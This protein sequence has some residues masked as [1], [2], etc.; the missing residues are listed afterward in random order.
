M[1]QKTEA[2]G[3]YDQIAS[4]LEDC[5]AHAKGDLTLK[6][7][8]LPAPPPKV[9]AHDIAALRRSLRMSQSVFAAVLNVSLKTIQ[10]WEQ[11]LREPNEASL[12]LI[13]IIESNPAIVEKLISEKS[14]MDEAVLSR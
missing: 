7:I 11:G 1:A 12:R 8:Q 9:A 14:S 6:T 13:Q 2:L 3:V 5:L 4:G 10:S